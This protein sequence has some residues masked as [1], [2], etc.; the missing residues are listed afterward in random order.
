MST[1]VSRMVSAGVLAVAVAVG[2]AGV[3]S[4]QTSNDPSPTPITDFANYPLGLGIIPPSCTAEGPEVVVNERFSV[5]GGPEVTDLRRLNLLPPAE[6]VTMR[7]DG[8]APGCEGIGVGLS[9]KI[10][11]STIFDPNIDQVGDRTAYCGPEAGMIPC[12][13][14]FELTLFLGDQPGDPMPPCYQVDASLG[15]PLAIVG[16]SGSFY[17]ILN[18][19]FN[20]LISAWNGGREPCGVPVTVTTLAPPTTPSTTPPPSISPTSASISPTSASISP[21]SASIGS[22]T[23]CPAG[24]TMGPAGCVAVAGVTATIPRTGAASSATSGAAGVLLILA[25]SAL[26]VGAGTI[27]RRARRL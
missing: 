2:G 19:Q 12:T 10:A 25:G 9:G 26:V 1:R 18:G 4:A 14:P 8:F 7:W 15:P 5:D 16:P 20:M 27:G 21:T 11:G 6:S 23:T 17:G 22:S 24:Q 13:A 3:A